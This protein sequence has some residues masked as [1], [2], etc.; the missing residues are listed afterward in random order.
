MLLCCLS[1]VFL[2]KRCYTVTQLNQFLYFLK[3]RGKKH[4]LKHKTFANFQTIIFSTHMD[5]N[6]VTFTAEL[7]WLEPL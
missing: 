2:G 7:Q 4:K 1:K 6:S 5:V 3:I